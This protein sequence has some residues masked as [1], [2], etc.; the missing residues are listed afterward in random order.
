MSIA[1]TRTT[2]SRRARTGSPGVYLV[3]SLLAVFSIGPVLVFIANSFKSRVEIAEQ[4]LSLPS[5]LSVDNYVAAWKTANLGVG[6]LNSMLIVGGTVVVVCVISGL[7]A[8]SLAR[9]RAPGGGA[10]VVYLLVSAALPVQMFLVPLFFLWTRIGL[11]DTRLGLAVIYCALFSPF[12]T[13]LL[14]SYFLSL[15]REL[16]E[17]ARLDGAG[18]LVV[19]TRIVMPVVWPGFLTAALVTGLFAYNEFLF[20][21][22]FI[23]SSSMKPVS[24]AFLSFQQGYTQNYALVAA[25]GVMMVL[26]MLLLFLA[27]QRRFVEGMT[28]AGLK[29]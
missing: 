29:G 15:P 12:A 14:R 5:S 27:L 21:V 6:L 28:A 23:Q 22:T 25:A 4:P 7:A 24:T 11:Y 18:E 2:R 26:P 17:A 13:L 20:A 1:A 19:L 9:L 3:L 10:V 8:Y 16:E